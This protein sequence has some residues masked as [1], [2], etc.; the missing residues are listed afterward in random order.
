MND[1]QARINEG[2][3]GADTRGRLH[4][5][6]PRARMDEQ[7]II[8]VAS[9]LDRESLR[10]MFSRASSETI[11]RRF[12]I[13]FPE[14]PERML[15][16]M[17]DVD[18]PSNECLLA[19]V[20]EEIVGHAMYVKLE[21]ATEAEMAIVVEDGWQSRGVGRSLLS[22]LAR[23]ARLQGV[24]TFVGEVLVE[25]RRMLGL[26]AMFAGTDRTITDGMFHVRMPLPV[27]VPTTRAA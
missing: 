21:D 24:E 12:H 27:P 16:L 14:V 23:R 15:A 3:E 1:T 5:D 17:L 20:G 8:R 4:G 13:P 10:R 7:V 18:P 26:A 25:N 9:S 6:G 19:V 11:Y 22:E 2:S